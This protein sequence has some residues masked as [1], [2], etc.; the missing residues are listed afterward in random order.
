MRKGII[1]AGGEGTR[2]YPL[3]KN[4]SKQLLP[5]YNKPMIYYPLSLLIN[6]GIKDI[7]IITTP[8]DNE[9]FR[10]L[11]G[12]GSQWGISISYEEQKKPNGIA[13]SFLIAEKW[14]DNSSSVLVLGDN[15]FFGHGL[16]D[17][18][19]KTFSDEDSATI[20][21]HEVIEPERYGVAKLDTKDNIIDLIEK[22]TSPISNWAVT[23]MYCYDKNAPIYTKTLKPSERGELEITDL[24]KIYLAEK[25]LNAEFLGQGFAWLDMGTHESLIEAANF[26][27]I[28]ERRQ[29]IKIADLDN[30][31]LN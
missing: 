1:L 14:L 10:K 25:N 6:G 18:T 29:G 27:K 5:I 2:L 22:P 20:F 7:L 28:I 24:N 8:R 26:V 13:Q 23:G 19:K 9:Q 15:F 17:L 30:L 4:T 16:I 21:L 12:D 11:L 3:T 31:K